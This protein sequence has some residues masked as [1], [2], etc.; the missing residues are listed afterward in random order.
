[1]TSF[2][3]RYQQGECV[4]VWA[5]LQR[6]GAEIRQEPLWSDAVAVARETMRRARFNLERVI[7]RLQAEGYEFGYGWVTEHQGYDAG[8]VA[9]VVEGQKQ[10]P[11]VPWSPPLPDVHER[12][13][14]VE[15]LI[16]GPLPL[17]LRAWYEVV[18]QVNFIGSVPNGWEHPAVSSAPPRPSLPGREPDGFF[19]LAQLEGDQKPPFDP[20]YVEPIATVLHRVKARLRMG[21]S[22]REYPWI[23]V[24]PDHYGKYYISGSGPYGMR[25]PDPTMDGLLEGEWHQ[26]TFVNYLRICLAWAGLPG[27]DQGEE[28]LRRLTA[29]FLRL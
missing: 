16:G 2:L 28:N 4:E 24:S 9:S 1:M 27:L 17:S 10:R 18:G 6:L 15:H 22:R 20:L 12:L 29:G 23:D 5:D 11:A 7:P 8:L 21:L 26:T 25:V 14:E 3:K 13:A 19:S